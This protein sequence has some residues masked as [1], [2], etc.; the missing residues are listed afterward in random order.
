MAFSPKMILVFD[1]STE[2]TREGTSSSSRPS[3]P[4]A[5]VAARLASDPPRFSATSAPRVIM[6]NNAERNPAL[7]VASYSA[8]GP[9]TRLTVAMMA[10]EAVSRSFSASAPFAIASGS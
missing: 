4:V 7:A 6:V 8:T 2:P 10:A 3:K 5:F 1:C 9:S